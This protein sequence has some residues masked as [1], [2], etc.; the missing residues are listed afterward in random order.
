[1]SHDGLPPPPPA[2]L[3]RPY[4]SNPNQKGGTLIVDGVV[5]AE[6]HEWRRRD[7]DG[8]RPEACPGCGNERLHV[9][10][11]I[12]R[13]RCMITLVRYQCP[14]CRAT[15]RMMPLF[16]ARMLWRSW[17]VVEAKTLESSPPA[18]GPS[19]PARTARR[20]RERLR[21]A[22]AALVSVMHERGSTAV[23]AMAAKVG[24]SATR[25]DLVV[26]FAEAMVA[27]IA[28]RL[29]RLATTVHGLAPGVRL[30]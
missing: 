29:A 30:M 27:P 19:V 28:Q 23:A 17:P 24:G 12:E 18:G 2:C 7:P 10:D 25:L 6:T 8:Y 26:A 3:W 11:Y 4:T 9:H 1:M 21:T 22:A 13:K 14:A 15:W 5:D 20:W 16:L